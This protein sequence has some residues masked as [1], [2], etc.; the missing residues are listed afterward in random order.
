M[1]RPCVIALI[2]L[3][4]PAV[5]ARAWDGVQ[6]LH[7]SADVAW[8]EYVDS[9]PTPVYWIYWD[10]TASG[11][12]VDLVASYGAGADETA[13]VDWFACCTG[14]SVVFTGAWPEN[15]PDNWIWNF[16]FFRVELQVRVVAW[17]GVRIVAARSVD[18]GH[19]TIDEHRVTVTDYG[20]LHVELLA[21][22]TGDEDVLELPP[23]T[24]F[25]VTL[26]VHARESGTHYAYDGQVRVRFEDPGP[27]PVAATTWS[28]VKGL[29]R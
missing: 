8:E 9:S 28:G 27:T 18:G 5:V 7:A 11:G 19:L 17:D 29:F 22:D 15:D 25:F 10:A 16:V 23:G 12:G 13:P 3:I 20:D 26:D 21:D 1:L 6:V 4:G 2:I 24:V 14:D